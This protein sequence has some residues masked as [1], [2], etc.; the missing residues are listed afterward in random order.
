[1][2]ILFSYSNLKVDVEIVI[3]EADDVAKEIEKEVETFHICR[4]VIGASSRNMITRYFS[5]LFLYVNTNIL[6]KEYLLKII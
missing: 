2:I 3:R 5:G 6:S 4:I 1:M